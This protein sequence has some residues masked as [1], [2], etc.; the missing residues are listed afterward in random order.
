M[1]GEDS[2]PLES[3]GDGPFDPSSQ[4]GA[5]Q[6]E[7]FD[8]SRPDSSLPDEQIN[9][10]PQAIAGDP[11]I[12][13][14]EVSAT[15][16]PAPAAPAANP[17]DVASSEALDTPRDADTP[18]GDPMAAAGGAGPA[19]P[20]GEQQ[21]VP[22]QAAAPPASQAPPQKNFD[23]L[24]RKDNYVRPDSNLPEDAEFSLAKAFLMTNSEKTEMNLYDHLSLTVMRILETRPNNA[25]DIFETIS[26]EIK[27]SKFNAELPGAPGSFKRA[28]EENR[29]NAIAKEQ[30]KLFERTTDEEGMMDDSG[31]GELP[32]IMDLSNLWEWANISFGKE[33]TFTLFLSLKKLVADKPL[34]SVRL[35]GKILGLQNPYIIVEGELRDGAVDDDEFVANP[36]SQ[37]E[38]DQ[39]KEEEEA[40]A[41]AIAAAP[42]AE[43]EEG[44]SGG[45]AAPVD[46]EAGLPKPKVKI[47]PPLPREQRNGVNKYVYYT[48]NYIGGPW[49]RLPDVIPEKL[50]ASRSICKY[51]TGD[52]THQIISYPAFNGNEAQYLRCQIAR[53]SAATVAS[54]SGYYMFDPEEADGEEAESST[55][56]INPEYE[57]LPNDALLNPTNWVHHV[58]Y[59]LPQ[60]RVTWENPMSGATNGSDDGDNNDDEGGSDNGSDDNGSN[61]GSNAEPIEPETGPA[62]LTSLSA[63]DDVAEGI[64]A[65]TSRICSNLSPSKFSPVLLRSTRWPG[66]TVVAY[67]DKFANIYVGDGIR[68]QPM[69]QGGLFIPPPLPD[70]MKEFV[71]V[72]KTEEE[73]AEE[74]A[75]PK[76]TML[77]EQKDPTVAEEQAYEELKKAK[78]EEGKEEE[79][80]GSAEGSEAPEEDED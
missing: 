23:F 16:P 61:A 70:V 65:W 64:P 54:P 5:D 41:N 63:D 14:A 1:D 25:V 6:N 49:V 42:S 57:G 71:L 47:I 36:P 28:P 24:R 34:K 13:D 55:I 48:C 74:G 37:E 2:N 75:P 66:A 56:I 69:S 60:G 73:E 33:E 45:A 77:V 32:D 40:A 31:E 4:Q 8:V 12:P 7:D 26:S 51:F 62:I 27:R 17:V 67:N 46:D 39:R 76:E 38:I 78:E 72:V 44:G 43:D 3:G 35:W 10:D 50:Q 80:E 15:G 29:W 53:I 79:E 11:Q 58:P 18:S 52:L 20:G 30:I 19:A 9:V 21:P 22:A 68:E 59:I